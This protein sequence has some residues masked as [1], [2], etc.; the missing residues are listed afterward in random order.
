VSGDT[1][2]AGVRGH[3]VG[4]NTGQGSAY[5][6][7][8]PPGGWAGAL[9]ES[10]KLIAS[11]GAAHDQLG[12]SVAA[13]GDTVVGGAPRADIGSKEGQGSAYVFDLSA[14]LQPPPP[15]PPPG[16]PPPPGPAPSGGCTVNG[17]P[18][19]VCLGTPGPDT[20]S[21]TPGPDTIAGLGGNDTIRGGGG[22]DRVS[23]GPGRDR[24]IGGPGNDRLQGDGGKDTLVGGPGRDRLNGGKS[25]DRC[26]RDSA[27]ATPVACE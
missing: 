3:K 27:D 8:K 2:V 11:D 1:V 24:L 4:N 22:N 13:S 7:V 15:I 18:G 12:S 19:Q 20:I 26:K 14:I 16:P 23:G 21:G 9:T 5:V 6:F 25:R 17:V 10:V